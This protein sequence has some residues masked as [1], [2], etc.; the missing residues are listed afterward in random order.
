MSNATKM[1]KSTKYLAGL[2]IKLADKQNLDKKFKSPLIHFQHF[3][4][5]CKYVLILD[6]IKCNPFI[7]PRLNLKIMLDILLTF[8]KDP[9]G[10]D[11]NDVPKSIG[12]FYF[13]MHHILSDIRKRCETNFNETTRLTKKIFTKQECEDKIEEKVKVTSEQI[14]KLKQS[15]DELNNTDELDK[16]YKEEKEKTLKKLFGEPFENFKKTLSTYGLIDGLHEYDKVLKQLNNTDITSFEHQTKELTKLIEKTDEIKK[17][18]CDKL[19]K[20]DKKDKTDYFKKH[21]SELIKILQD[22][23]KDVIKNTVDLQDQHVNDAVLILDDIELNEDTINSILQE[24]NKAAAEKAEKERLAAEKAEKE[25]LAA[26]EKERQ[27]KAAAEEKERQEKERQ[28]KER[29]EKE[30]KLK[31]EAEIKTK[32]EAFLKNTYFNFKDQTFNTFADFATYLKSLETE[33]TG[34]RIF[35]DISTITDEIQKNLNDSNVTKLDTQSLTAKITEITTYF[36]DL[37]KEILY[38]IVK[39]EGHVKEDNLFTIIK[40]C[41][42]ALA[43]LTKQDFKDLQ[44]TNQ[45]QLISL[46]DMKRKNIEIEKN[47]YKKMYGVEPP[48]QLVTN[49]KELNTDFVNKLREI[50]T[51]F[52]LQNKCNKYFN[53]PN[54]LLELMNNFNNFETCMKPYE[55]ALQKDLGNAN[56]DFGNNN[57]ICNKISV[58]Y[59]AHK[60]A[61]ATKKVDYK[62]RWGEPVPEMKTIQEYVKA[63]EQRLAEEKTAK[64][65]AEQKKQADEKAEK[66]EK[67]EREKQEAEQKKLAKEEKKRQEAETKRLAEEVKRLAEAEQKKLAEAEQKKLAEAARQETEAKEEKNRQEAEAKA[68]ANTLT[69]IFGQTVEEFKKTLETAISNGLPFPDAV[70]EVDELLSQLDQKVYKVSEKLLQTNTSIKKYLI[71][72]IYEIDKKDKKDKTDYSDKHIHELIEIL[73]PKVNAIVKE[74]QTLTDKLDEKRNSTIKTK[75]S[76]LL[77]I[78]AKNYTNLNQDFIKQQLSEI[79]DKEKERLANLLRQIHVFFPLQL[80]ERNYTHEF[81]NITVDNVKEK[82][83]ENGISH[84]ISHGM[85][86]SF[87]FTTDAEI[88][89][90]LQ[91]IIEIVDDKLYATEKQVRFVKVGTIED[92]EDKW[93]T[94]NS[95]LIGLLKKIINN[96][97]NCLKYLNDI[98]EILNYQT[99]ITCINTNYVIPL[100]RYLNKSLNPKPLNPKPFT[101]NDTNIYQKLKTLVDEVDKKKIVEEAETKRVEEAEKKRVEEAEKKRVAEVEAHKKR[102]EVEAEKKKVAEEAE[103]PKLKEEIKQN[104]IYRI[105][106]DTTYVDDKTIEILRTLNATLTAINNNITNETTEGI[107]RKLN[108]VTINTANKTTLQEFININKKIILFEIEHIKASLIILLNECQ[109]DTVKLKIFNTQITLLLP[110]YKFIKKLYTSSD[111]NPEI[112]NIYP[113]LLQND[114]TKI[115]D[116]REILENVLIEILKLF[117]MPN[118][119]ECQAC[120]TTKI[121]A[122]AKKSIRCEKFIMFRFSLSTTNFTDF[123]TRYNNYTKP[124]NISTFGV[125]FKN[126]ITENNSVTVEDN[127]IYNDMF[128]TKPLHVDDLITR[129]ITKLSEYY[130]P[131][132]H[133]DD[134]VLE[135]FEGGGSILQKASKSTKNKFQQKSIKKTNRVFQNQNHKKTKHIHRIVKNPKTIFNKKNAKTK[136]NNRTCRRSSRRRCR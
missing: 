134:L 38:C 60:D 22:K 31:K 102:L 49:W 10:N 20:V 32:K 8:Y 135:E 24:N 133:N 66:A 86:K 72:T 37:Y 70:S 88:K 41:K 116:F 111:N 71:D 27:E 39:K 85:F 68:Y 48:I 119:K 62:K 95:D 125:V 120:D 79:E 12:Q 58:L 78:N 80:I 18:L 76:K 84:G 44:L 105:I 63:D 47:I 65:V 81:Y 87:N 30:K 28:E 75:E 23:L 36:N 104:N 115:E 91:Q 83:K 35:D 5:V 53:E 89:D 13:Y 96:Q 64:Q 98:S 97:D 45:N 1:E 130:F 74:H 132:S 101:I 122:S 106:F 9:F 29:Q 113:R 67:A 40:S 15:I 33:L 127:A 25:R 69:N 123:C 100:Q 110:I 136:K 55:T 46:T 50:S 129:N 77:F 52:N 94:N 124:V 16:E 117:K 26:A 7:D 103:K 3:Q 54:E 121:I 19:K 17:D 82:A 73:T 11:A 112:N 109:T 34:E 61:L 99:F 57:S 51:I 114:F 21:I 126:A 90:T 42:D 118:K 14:N 92:I 59:T 93:K 56:V 2:M 43:K 108:N 128:P 107:S 131:P 6:E 4:K